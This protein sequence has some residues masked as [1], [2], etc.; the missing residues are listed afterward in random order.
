[1]SRAARQ[2]TR[3]GLARRRRR[4]WRLA[5]RQWFAS[6]EPFGL[7][8][9]ALRQRVALRE[10]VTRGERVTP[11]E[12]LGL[13]EWVALRELVGL[14]QR[15]GLRLPPGERRSVRAQVCHAVVS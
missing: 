7:R 11:G 5:L 3:R 8:R 12:L 14:R 4:C 9:V 10:R 2:Q 1:M 15:V 13:R 6:G